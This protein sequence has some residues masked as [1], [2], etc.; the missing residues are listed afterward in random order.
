[1]SPETDEH[2]KIKS[3]LLKKLKEIYGSGLSE[4]PDSGHRKDV[5]IVI[6]NG[7]S[8]FIEVIT[9]WLTQPTIYLTYSILIGFHPVN[10]QPVLSHTDQDFPGT[11]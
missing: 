10:I 5:K 4:Y 1:M 2:N 3:I 11:R 7:I 8:I 6:P 9:I